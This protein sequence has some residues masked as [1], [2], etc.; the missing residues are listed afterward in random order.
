MAFDWDGY[1]ARMALRRFGTIDSET[2]RLFDDLL[3]RILAELPESIQQLLEEVPLIVE[4]EPSPRLL[5]EMGL[6][7]HDTLLC[8]LH[9]GIPLTHRSVEHSATMPD[10][11]MLFRG[12][13]LRTAGYRLGRQAASAMDELERQIRITLLHEIGHHFGLD[14]DD[15]AAL[16]YG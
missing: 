1:N 7:R 4:D 13:I 14:E 9:W 10:R 12:P 3:E 15:L 11:M 5:R 2:R 6:S 16:G 8:G